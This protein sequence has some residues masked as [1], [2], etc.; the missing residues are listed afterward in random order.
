[1]EGGGAG[2]RRGRG[3]ERGGV[4][5]G[6]FC[7]MSAFG[8]KRTCQSHSAMSASGVKRSLLGGA[9]I[10]AFDPKRTSATLP[11]TMLR[12]EPG[13]HSLDAPFL[14]FSRSDDDPA[15]PPRSRSGHALLSRAAPH[16]ARARQYF[17]PGNAMGHSYP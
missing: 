3:V 14:R 16:Y 7:A 4:G 11:G 6:G 9:P 12:R 2:H 1:G 8:T 15:A 17:F 10:S 5:W 13:N